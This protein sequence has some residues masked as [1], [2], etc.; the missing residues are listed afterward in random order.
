MKAVATEFTKT[1]AAADSDLGQKLKSL[2]DKMA[3]AK[4]HLG[5]LQAGAKA[6]G[7]AI[8]QLADKVGNAAYEYGP[9][10]GSHVQL[11]QAMG[12]GL[13]RAAS[14]AG[15]AVSALGVAIGA[16]A[17]AAGASLAVVAAQVDS[18]RNLDDAARA[19]KVSM[20]A[21]QNLNA[22]GASVGIDVAQMN[23][24]MAAFAQKLRE[25]QVAGGD[26][27]DFLE[28]NNIAIK[29]SSGNLLPVQQVFGKIAELILT[30]NNEMDRLAALSKLGFSADMLRLIERQTDAVKT[31]AA[32]SKTA[33]DDVLKQGITDG[34]ALSAAWTGTWT[35]VKDG[36]LSMSVSVLSAIG[37]IEHQGA[38]KFSELSNEAK[39]AFD[40]ITGD[41]EGAARAMQS[42][43]AAQRHEVI[44]QEA[45][46]VRDGK[47]PFGELNTDA[48]GP[49]AKTAAAPSDKPTIKGLYDKSGGGGAAKGNRDD[50]S[51]EMKGL[52]DSIAAA[53][54]AEKAK[55]SL[56]AEGVKLHLMSVDANLAA[57]KS[58]LDEEYNA[59]RALL[60]KESL[61]DGIKAQQKQA[62]NDKL[63]A[64]DAK[65]ASDSQ[66]LL[67]QSVES[68]IQMWDK[69]VDT[70]SSSLSFGIMGM[71]EG[72]KSFRQV[73][74]SLAQGVT[75]QFVKM[76]VDMAANWAKAQ[77]AQVVLSQTTEGQKTAAAIAGAAARGGIAGG[78]AS[79]SMAQTITAAVK[80]IT[81]SASE[82]F[83]GMF[84]FLAPFMGP[85]AAGPA[86][87]AQGAVMSVA[88]FDIG[89]WSIPQD[90]LAMVHRNEL[91]MPAAEAG[92]F[93][94]MLSGATKGGGSAGT[95]A[96][97]G[98]SHVHLNVSALDAGSVKN[99]LGGN[100]RQIM[101]A[102]NQAVADGNHLGLRRL[103]G[104]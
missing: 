65:Y 15:V 80:S 81:V 22:A 92:A 99:W 63:K 69:M 47:S 4:D 86:A 67:M 36:A 52:E 51:A 17:V 10:T 97:G 96:R 62:I 38:A 83:A 42:A 9:W 70:M 40:R 11:A 1:G 44:R 34:E 61:V 85:A 104:G 6:G 66:K 94:S 12:E 100:S 50:Q 39:A 64:L 45:M 77:I 13:V 2:G 27:A 87:A 98:D 71:I 23:Q 41:A 18:L 60:Q 89:A 35:A 91:V 48:F 28:K 53:R 103:A 58:A 49:Q 55:E 3:A 21:L 31:F 93:R 102:I 43:F 29:D 7:D 32:S 101:K 84:G 59:E 30:S 19:A 33:Q 68:Q 24:E 56:Y 26:L 72:T 74:Q 54:T 57:S 14:G 46:A 16:V 78:E 79:A 76:G 73:L 25:A 82:T 75:Q 90:Q 88:A 8:K 20:T 95:S 5:G 37:D